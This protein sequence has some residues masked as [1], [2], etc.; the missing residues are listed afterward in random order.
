M[1]VLN[2]LSILTAAGS[3]IAS[4]CHPYYDCCKGCQTI[5]TDEEGNWGSENGQWCF[6][7]EKKCESVLG[8]CKFEAIGYP[9]CSHCDVILT[10]DDGNW[11]AENG[12]WCGIPENCGSTEPSTNQS[13]APTENFFDNELYISPNYVKEIESTIPD[14]SPELQAKAKNVEKVS[15][16][17]WLA[18]EGAPNDVAPHLKAAGSKTVTFILYMIPT[19]DCNSLASAGGVSDLDKY[20]GYVDKIANTIKKFPESKVVMVIEPD[21][22][23]NL[24]T[25]ETEA[26]KNVHTLHKQALA[27]AANVFG[28]MSNVSAYLDAA[29]SKWLGW[30]ADKVAAVVKE[31]LDNAPNANIRGFSTNVSNYMPIE[32]EYEYHQKLHDALEEV[33]IKDKRFIVDTGRS[34]VDVREE[35]D[36]NQTWCNLIY[37]GLGEPSRGSPDPENMPLLDAFMWLKPPGEADGSDTGSRADPVC[38]REDSFP[39]SPDAGSWFGEYFASMLEKSPFYSDDTVEPSE[40]STPTNSTEPAESTPGSSVAPTENFFDNELYISP[41]YVKEIES[42]IPDLSPEL[43]AK[44]K[45]VEKV[46]S[47]VWLAYE[48]APNDVAPHLKAAGSKTVTFILYMIPTR[49][50]NSLAS[51]GGVSDLDKYKGYVDKIANTIKKFPES[52][53]VMVIEPDTLG[54]LITGETEACKNVHTLHKQAL[55]YAANVFGNMSNV[56]AYLDAAHSKWL[57]WAADKVA[58]VV[59]EILDNAPNAN[60]RGFSTNVSNYMPIE[61]EYEYHQKLHDALEEVGI[62]DKRFIVDTGRSG[63]DVREEFDVNQTWCNLIY[64]GLG[65]PSR[66]SPDP[67]NMPLL[68]AFMWLKP[69]GEADG[70]D[71]GS[72]ADPVCGREDSFPGSPDAGSWFGEYFASMLE[73]S[74]FYSDDT[75]EPS[76]PSTPTNSTEPAESTPGSSVA[77]T[78]NFFDNELYISPNYVKEIESTI[79]DLSPELQAKAKNVEKVSSAVWLAYEG[80]P[81]DVAPHLKAAGSKTVTFI[82]YMIPTRD[83]NSLAS[84]GGVSDLD[85]YKGYVD[86]IANTIKKFPESKVVMVIEPDTLGNLITGET[87]A[88]KNVHTLHKQALAYAAN[89]FG[90]MSNVSAYLDAAHSKWLGWA[91]DKVAAVVKEI[92]DNAPNANIRGFSTNVSNYMPIEAEYEYHQKL[93]DALEEVGIKDKRFIVDTGRSGVDVREEFDVN[94]TWCNLIYAGLGEPSR[95]SPDPENMPLLDAFMWLKPPG[96]ADGSDTGSRADPVCGREDS[97]PGSPDAGSWFGEYFASMLEKSPF[98]SDDTV[99][100]SEQSTPTSSTESAEPT[101]Q[102]SSCKFEEIG[103]SCCSHC[104]VVYTDEDGDWGTEDGK[105]CGIPENCKGY[106]CAVNYYIYLHEHMISC[107]HVDIYSTCDRRKFKNKD[108]YLAFLDLKKVY[109]SVPIFNVLM[110]THHLGKQRLR[111]IRKMNLRKL[112]TT[113]NSTLS[114]LILHAIYGYKFDAR[115]AKAVNM[116]E[117][118]CPYCFRKNKSSTDSNSCNEE[119]SINN[120]NNNNRNNISIGENCVNNSNFLNN[121]FFLGGNLRLSLQK[122]CLGLVFDKDCYKRKLTRNINAELHT[123]EGEDQNFFQKKL[124]CILDNLEEDFEIR[125]TEIQYL[126]SYRST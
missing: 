108:T 62:K 49:D 83:C 63:V 26:C 35:F 48:G 4:K 74:P 114:I 64:A 106:A 50:C 95:G 117:Y 51:A 13:V 53:V 44:A 25:G 40:P 89:V 66:G 93:H 115:V 96:E 98:Y 113:Y 46:S 52:K 76:E 116:I 90:N 16:A 85:K 11:G 38:G 59:K 36:V 57:G 126:K 99:E 2:I 39:G 73:K 19:R 27:Y 67:E 79:P 24:I 68:D 97:F 72:R 70:S 23:G 84:A 34:G 109:D 71:T 86:K 94:Q 77:P 111:L 30:A 54:N 29:H 88:C 125:I 1:K 5:L 105:W 14:L 15:S 6:V 20:K 43:Q 33:G 91:A 120:N 60:I 22:L 101:S 100:P 75:V 78:E 122:L 123:S 69:P 87:E 92:L 32:A 8:T 18:Y 37:A 12:Q 124:L 31:I 103:Y 41:N 58:A 82:L 119:Y 9:C 112:E 3:A 45:N 42:T 110:K 118:S 104:D 61:A 80:A 55:A 7:D 17:V 121:D 56:S 65:E 102:T 21:T 107:V 10:D 81:N 28:N 47:A